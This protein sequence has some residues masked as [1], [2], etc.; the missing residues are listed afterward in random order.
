M[1]TRVKKEHPCWLAQLERCPYTK[2]GCVLIPGQGTYGRQPFNVSLSLPPPSLILKKIKKKK[3]I[4]TYPWVRITKKE[5]AFSQCLS[6]K[7]TSALL[8]LACQHLKESVK[9]GIFLE[10][11]KSWGH[12]VEIYSTDLKTTCDSSSWVSNKRIR[13][14]FIHNPIRQRRGKQSLE[15]ETWLSEEPAMKPGLPSASDTI[16]EAWTL[17]LIRLLTPWGDKSNWKRFLF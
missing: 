17:F 15:R 13:T 16:T 6:F 4:K 9:N 10:Y 14:I 7:T 1:S 3:S 8:K 11:Q 5:N 2:T 12:R